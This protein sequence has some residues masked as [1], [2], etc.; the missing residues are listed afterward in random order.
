MSIEER[1]VNFDKTGNCTL[2]TNEAFLIDKDDL[3]AIVENI[4]DWL[5]LEHKRTLWIQEGRKTKLKPMELR[6][7]YPWCKTLVELVD[8]ELIF[9][10]Y[11]CIKDNKFNFRESITEEEKK[12]IREYVYLNR[13]RCLMR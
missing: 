12:R 3:S 9:K 13:R 2:I 8:E 5:E 4:I 11:F 10:E 7:Q 6:M 1:L